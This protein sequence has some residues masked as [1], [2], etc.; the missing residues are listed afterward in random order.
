ML[1]EHGIRISITSLFVA[2]VEL[3]NQVEQFFRN[4]NV[5]GLL[6]ELF[7][8][9]APAM[10]DLSAGFE[11]SD[12]PFDVDGAYLQYNYFGGSDFGGG[13]NFSVNRHERFKVESP[14][15]LP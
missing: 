13:T 10:S 2:R 15:E 5:G 14:L 6:L 9:Q 7:P 3:S 1:T 4:T 11:L 12:V 8:T